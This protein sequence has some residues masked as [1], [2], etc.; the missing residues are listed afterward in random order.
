MNNNNNNKLSSNRKRFPFNP[1]VI[2]Y[3]QINTSTAGTRSGLV[4]YVVSRINLWTFQSTDT[5][6]QHT[7]KATLLFFSL[8]RVFFYL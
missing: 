3:Q 6:P 1:I 4:Y 5:N 2:N 7:E 8:L